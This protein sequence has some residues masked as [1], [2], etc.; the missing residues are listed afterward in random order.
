MTSTG[1][2]AALDRKILPVPVVLVVG[3]F[4]IRHTP[5]A[6]RAWARVK[7]TYDRI[8]QGFGNVEDEPEGT[9]PLDALPQ[10]VRS[11]NRYDAR[12]LLPVAVSDEDSA[13]SKSFVT[14]LY[15]CFRRLDVHAVISCGTA[16]AT[17][18]LLEALDASD[19]P[20][21]ITIDTTIGT[22]LMAATPQAP[23]VGGGASWE[24]RSNILRLIPSNEQQAQAIVTKAKRLVEKREDKNV[25]LF[26]DPTQDLYVDDLAQAI[27][28]QL[29]VDPSIPL[30]MP[31]VVDLTR[32]RKEQDPVVVVVGYYEAL[33]KVHASC[34]GGSIIASDGCYN[35]PR[36]LSLLSS[37]RTGGNGIE[38]I[39]DGSTT[40]YWTHPTVDPSWYAHD[41]YRV[42]CNLW[43]NMGRRSGHMIRRGLRPE[44]Q[45]MPLARRMAEELQ[46]SSPGVYRFRAWDN[47][48]G[49]YVVDQVTEVS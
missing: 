48:R 7:D 40:L 19:V 14:R 39:Q 23:S 41:A 33:E 13:D 36:V 18:G 21:V 2:L 43:R 3:D 42:V 27:R 37:H 16:S 38:G 47:Q 31:L 1:L 30:S 28:A 8:G 9:E 26:A 11:D 25:W 12:T 17:R 10:G 45:L 35:D 20:V 44:E 6:S 22:V 5:F 49:G 4:R 15:T 32:I 34:R 29:E 24:L 46:K